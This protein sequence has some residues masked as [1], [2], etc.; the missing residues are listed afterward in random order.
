VKAAILLAMLRHMTT[1]GLSETAGAGCQEG[2]WTLIAAFGLSIPVFFVTSYGWVLWIAVPVAESFWFRHRRG[3][4]DIGGAARH[5]GDGD[6][7]A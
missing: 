4:A 2:S 1:H 3:D 6:A 7:D 5:T